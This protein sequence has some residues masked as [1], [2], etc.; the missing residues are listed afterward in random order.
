MFFT[1]RAGDGNADK[2][3][4]NETAL[5]YVFEVCFLIY[6]YRYIQPST[7]IFIPIIPLPNLT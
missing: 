1:I 7:S 3:E 4:V 6:S 2:H 5:N